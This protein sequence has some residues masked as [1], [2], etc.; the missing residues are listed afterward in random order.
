MWRVM[1]SIRSSRGSGGELLPPPC[2]SVCTGSTSAFFCSFPTFLSHYSPSPTN[3]GFLSWV[4]PGCGGTHGTALD[5]TASRTAAG[6]ELGSAHP[7]A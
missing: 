2:Q 6:A 4:W 1:R 5:T 3:E 7:S